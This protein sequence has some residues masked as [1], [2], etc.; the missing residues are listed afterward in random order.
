LGDEK[1]TLA[2]IKASASG[3]SLSSVT[4][5]SLTIIAYGAILRLRGGIREFIGWKK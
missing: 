2:I 4:G 3:A 5:R 1:E